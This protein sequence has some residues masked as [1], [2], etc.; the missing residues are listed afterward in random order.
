MV[1]TTG[2]LIHTLSP[3]L[4]SRALAAVGLDSHGKQLI[5]VWDISG[6]IDGVSTASVE[7]RQTTDFNVRRLRFSPYEEDR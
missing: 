3:P 5:V 4:D 2:G 6:V 7:V 1:L